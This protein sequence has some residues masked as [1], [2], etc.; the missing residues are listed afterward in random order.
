LAFAKYRIQ[1]EARCKIN[2]TLLNRSYLLG[3]KNSRNEDE[4]KNLIVLNIAINGVIA[5]VTS[6]ASFASE[7]FGS[8]IS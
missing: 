7:Y 8:K 3:K 4:I 6:K 5:P 1:K 2:T